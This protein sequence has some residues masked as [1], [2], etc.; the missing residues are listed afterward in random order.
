MKKMNEQMGRMEK[1]LKEWG[2]KLDDLA[3]KAEKADNDAKANYYK[4]ID[5][6][7]AKYHAASSK[8]DE[9]KNGGFEKWEGF[10]TGVEHAW[11]DIEKAFRSLKD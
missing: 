11:K 8:L 5:N 10:K 9:A 1:Q 4:Q 7:K 2:V 3:A 6:L